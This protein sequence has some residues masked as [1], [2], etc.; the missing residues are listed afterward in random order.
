MKTK[1]LF[2]VMFFPIVM[3]AQL[4]GEHVYEF[5]SVP[6]SPRQAAL[7]GSAIG[8]YD[9]DISLTNENPALFSEATD[10]KLGM[11]Y[12][13]YI[14]DVNFGYTSYA[15]HFKN[16]GIV[17]LGL[18]YMS[19][20]DFRGFDENAVE[21]GSFSTSEIALNLSYAKSFDSVLCIGATV[22]PI[23]SK[24]ESVNSLGLA[25]DVG[26]VY[27]SRKKP[28]T[29]ALVFNNMG[30]QITKYYDESA[31]IPFEI[32]AGISTKLAHAPF[33]FS[34]VAHNLQDLD[35]TALQSNYPE[36][37]NVN[38]VRDEQEE[39]ELVDKIMRHMIFGVEFTP[40][41]SFFVRGGFN[42]LRR[43]ELKLDEKPGMVGFS[44]GFGFKIKKLNFSYANVRYN[45]AGTSNNFAITTNI[46]S[47]FN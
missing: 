35:L 22:K 5:L 47:F 29:A 16:I 24:L 33:R 46:N 6:V 7:G 31:P 4:G 40:T 44:W 21:T 36:P 15:K 27:N 45:F 25:M 11:Q 41:K 12:I 42:Y 38:Q 32:K 30:T 43:Q 18:Q 3:L 34:I 26:I 19:G 28:F 39:P 23:Y 1:L 17:G 20:G 10:G 13:N 14:S 2:L 8:I 9:G 37:T